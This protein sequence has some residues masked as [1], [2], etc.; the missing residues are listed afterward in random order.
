MNSIVILAGIVL[1]IATGAP[2]MV[3]IFRQHPRG[4]FVLFFAEMWERFSYYGMRGLLVFYLTQHFLFGDAFAAS[5]YGSYATLVYLIP[6]VGGVVADRFL[7][8]RKAVA[9]GALLLVAGHTT[10]AIEGTPARQVLTWHGAHYGFQVNGLGAAREAKVLVAGRPYAFGQSAD[11]AF[12]ITGLPPGSPLPSALPKGTFQLSVSGRDKGYV[13]LFYLALALIIMGVGFL[14]S[15]I[16][17][18]VG[19]LY[20]ERDPRRDP[21]FTLYYY[22]VNL[23]AFWAAVLCGYLGENFGWSWGFGAAGVGMLAGYLT[24]QLGRPLLQG[25]GEPPDPARLARRL[26]GP[27]NL[28]WLTYLGGLAA[29]AAIWLLV[30]HNQI[31]G[32]SLGLGWVLGIGYV[33]WVLVKNFG[34]V[35]MERVALS[36]LL[37]VGSIVFFTLFEQAAT[38]LNL[39]AERNTQ[40]DLIHAPASL[41]LF[42]RQVFFGSRAMWQAAHPAAGTVWVDMGLSAAQTQSF[43]AGFILLFAPIFAALWAW[44]GKRGRDPDPMIKFGLGLA[45]VGLGFLVIVWS[46]GLADAHLRV[47]LLVLAFAYLL[48]TTGELCLSPVGLSEITKLAPAT[49]FST[50]MSMWFLAVSAAE[51]IGSAIARLAGTTTAG[52]QVLDPA[53]ALRASLAVFQAIGWAGVACGAV[54]LILSPFVRRWAHGVNDPLPAGEA[55]PAPAE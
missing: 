28:E 24:F 4:L 45:Q 29:V 33:V 30:Q 15:N 37:M 27:L 47:P 14:K 50:M 11:G 55:I 5:T 31:V 19:Q 10:M 53:A 6:L 18:I 9:F 43:N 25:R 17:A 32:W 40:L 49:L 22:G 7:G 3:Q 36:F 48:H 26:V 46:A 21:G 44:L 35:E 39:F 34:R 20:V 2:V 41:G 38:S 54:F 42:G 13:D 1:T 8:A 23:G 52:G 12:T 51:F 16:S